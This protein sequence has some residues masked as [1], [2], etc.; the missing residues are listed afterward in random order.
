[1]RYLSLLLAAGLVSGCS[2]EKVVTLSGIVLTG[3]EVNDAGAGIGSESTIIGE[4]WQRITDAKITVLTP[5]DNPRIVAA[6]TTDSEGRYQIVLERQEAVL[7][8]EKTG[9]KTVQREITISPFGHFLRN[10]V[11][12]APQK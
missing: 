5:G 9:F 12:M 10:T 2:T 8:V 4:Q 1:M 3:K 7:R 6:T 11:I